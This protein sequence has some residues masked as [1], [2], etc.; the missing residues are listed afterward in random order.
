MIRSDNVEVDAL[1]CRNRL[2][3]A[4]FASLYN[5]VLFCIVLCTL[6][7]NLPC[8]TTV[9]KSQC[10]FKKGKTGPTLWR[11]KLKPF[12]LYDGIVLEVLLQLIFYYNLQR[13]YE[14][15]IMYFIITSKSHARLVNN[16]NKVVESG[17]KF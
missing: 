5:F 11:F 6:L 14:F 2:K 7:I 4:V 8:E 10:L 9:E 17:Q 16:K 3:I 13:V 1:S 12:N 15:Y